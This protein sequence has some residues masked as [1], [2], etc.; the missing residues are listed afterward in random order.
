MSVGVRVFV[1]RGVHAY[2]EWVNFWIFILMCDECFL[3]F[4]SYCRYW[5][6]ILMSYCYSSSCLYRLTNS[7]RTVCI[8]LFYY[9]DKDDDK[10]M[11]NELV[12][13]LVRDEFVIVC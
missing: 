7:F 11:I 12:S 9:V 5:T 2:S 13:L 8:T 3:S 6:N 4:G 10:K 1:Q